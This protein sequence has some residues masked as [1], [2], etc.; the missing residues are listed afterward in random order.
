MAGSHLSNHDAEA[1][2]H[3]HDYVAA[4]SEHD[5]V[6]VLSFLADDCL[7]EDMADGTCT[8]GKAAVRAYAD[9]FLEAFPDVRF[10]TTNA[11]I[12]GNYAAIEWTQA[13]TEA[14]TAT[15]QTVRGVSIIEMLDGK[16][17]RVTEW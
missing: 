1:V 10:E 9:S 16:F 7:F 14:A 15:K 5:V 4:W 17:T 8:H 13:G 6:K 2:G 3:L 11:F 12:S